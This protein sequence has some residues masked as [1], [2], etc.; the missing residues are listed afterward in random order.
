MQAP[1][2]LSKPLFLQ[3]AALEEEHG[4]ARSAMEVY[5]QAVRTVPED[6][7][8]SVYDQYLSRASTFFGIAKVCRART[9]V[10]YALNYPPPHPTVPFLPAAHP[11]VALHDCG[12]SEAAGIDLGWL[13]AHPHVHPEHPSTCSMCTP[14]VPPHGALTAAAVGPL[15]SSSGVLL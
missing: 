5:D 4:M 7:R 2:E 9:P 6:E 10:P 12:N 8:L 15:G 13:C 3:Y 11:H 1:P 14:H